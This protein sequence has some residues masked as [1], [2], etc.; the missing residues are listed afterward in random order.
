VRPYH[1]AWDNGVAADFNRLEAAGALAERGMDPTVAQAAVDLLADGRK[2]VLRS[3]QV[4]IT[5]RP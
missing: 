3:G 1:V 2:P 4:T 5:Y